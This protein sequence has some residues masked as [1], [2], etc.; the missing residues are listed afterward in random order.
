MS[1][2]TI[3][4][5]KEKLK[6]VDIDLQSLRDS[7]TSSRKLEVLS[8]YRAYIEDEIKFLEND[9]RSRKSTK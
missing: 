7:G 4:E 5:L 3:S 9:N 6:I 1:D 2:L 8:E